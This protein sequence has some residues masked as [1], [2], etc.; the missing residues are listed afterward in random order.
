MYDN[1]TSTKAGFLLLVG[2]LGETDAGPFA[3]DSE[4]VQRRILPPCCARGTRLNISRA[5]A[6]F[7]SS[8]V[9]GLLSNLPAVSVGKPRQAEE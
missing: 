6:F 8:D 9:A 2:I 1:A 3:S 7:V 4:S 5:L